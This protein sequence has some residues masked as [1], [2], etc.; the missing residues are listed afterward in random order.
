MPLRDD[1]TVDLGDLTTGEAMEPIHPGAILREEFLDPLG[2][3]A[4]RLAKSLGVPKNRVTAIVNGERAITSDTALR[5][6]RF[7]G[8]TAEFWVNLQGHYDLEVA[9][10]DRG[11]EIL[12]TVEPQD[13][14]RRTA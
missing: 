9:R 3:S 12:D 4:Y 1:E 14:L 13:R 10:R 5:L 2:I 7:F 6:A 8:V 11:A